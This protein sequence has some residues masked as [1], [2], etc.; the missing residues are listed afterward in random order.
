MRPRIS[1][2]EKVARALGVSSSELM[3]SLASWPATNMQPCIFG[4]PKVFH[5]GQPRQTLRLAYELA[6]GG[7]LPNDLRLKDKMCVNAGC[8]NVHHYRP[9]AHVTWQER[10]GL[11]SRELA[12]TAAAIPMPEDDDEGDIVDL[13]EMITGADGGVHR[14]AEDLHCQWS[15]YDISLIQTALDRIRAVDGNRSS[16]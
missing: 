4:K 5:D 12:E 2:A 15:M 16:Q 9:K 8:L 14:S 6:T 13:I 1:L 7:P 10:V 11:V 3:A